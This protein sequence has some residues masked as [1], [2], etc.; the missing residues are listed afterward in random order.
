MTEHNWRT[1]L[2]V[3]WGKTGDGDTW[4][5]L[6]QHLEDAAAVAGLLWDHWLPDS[7]KDHIAAALPGGHDDGRIL[8]TWLAG[9]HDLSLIHI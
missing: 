3:L 6:W 5:P 7:A 9:V 4:L 8:L 2:V 1:P